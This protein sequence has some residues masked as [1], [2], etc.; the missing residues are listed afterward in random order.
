M[1]N[2][3]LRLIT[4]ATGA[5]MVASAG[6]VGGAALSA[7]PLVQSALACTWQCGSGGGEGTVSPAGGQLHADSHGIG[8]DLDYYY[9]GKAGATGLY[10]FTAVKF[11]QEEHWVTSAGGQLLVTSDEVTASWPAGSRVSSKISQPATLSSTGGVEFNTLSGPVAFSSGPLYFAFFQP[12]KK[13][14]EKK[15]PALLNSGYMQFVGLVTLSAARLGAAVGGYPGSG[16]PVGGA[17]PTPTPAAWVLR[18][19][20]TP[21]YA[22]VGTSNRAVF[23][24]CEAPSRDPRGCQGAEVVVTSPNSGAASTFSIR[25]GAPAGAGAPGHGV[26]AAHSVSNL[27]AGAF[28]VLVGISSNKSRT[29]EYIAVA[30]FRGHGRGDQVRLVDRNRKAQ[31]SLPVAGR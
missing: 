16:Q 31:I 22:P 12:L 18:L 28:F 29:S 2:R 25:I 23:A 15:G 8:A 7:A 3:T 20:H 11:V 5:A 30:S 9:K 10:E 21:S 14:P 24:E 6:L 1:M 26:V 17:T 13:N 19:A 27:Q 4:I